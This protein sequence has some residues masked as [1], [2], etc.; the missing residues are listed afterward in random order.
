MN[1]L[2]FRYG[3]TLILLVLSF[4][5]TGIL[6]ASDREVDTFDDLSAWKVVRSAAIAPD[7]DNG[8]KTMKVTGPGLVSRT[9]LFPML[10][11]YGFNRYQGVSFRIRGDGPENH[12]AVGVTGYGDGLYTCYIP[13]KG[14]EW[15]TVVLAWSDFLPPRNSVCKGLGTPDEPWIGID[16]ISFGDYMRFGY[17]RR[18]IPKFNYWIDDF[19]L[20]EAAVPRSSPIKPQQM[21][22]L[23][24]ATAKMKS[25]E[26]ALIY[27][28]GDAISA[29]IGV[30][31][32]CYG[33]LLQEKLRKIYGN[34]K[35][36]V[37]ITAMG[38][39]FDSDALRIFAERDFSGDK[40]DL[41][42]IHIGYDEKR[43]AM[44]PAAFKYILNDY[45]D[46][47]SSLTAGK[48]AV[49]LLPTLPGQGP[50][51]TMMDDYAGIIR[52]IARERGLAVCDIA[53]T[54]KKMGPAR[55]QSHYSDMPYVNAAGHELIAG[56]LADYIANTK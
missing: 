2:S 35:I 14:A 29:G 28:A 45:L 22:P 49:L 18:E 8:N 41:L 21:I 30:G 38:G 17:C 39:G 55:L 31:E 13:V 24:N 52:E 47:V 53:A 23:D 5:V 19:K 3:G 33:N 6:S 56:Q 43:V 10:E 12:V 9:Y 42:L 20:I 44:A 48:T 4:A 54:F 50:L 34:D 27:C 15:Q 32:K 7:L 36:K 37:K 16:T 51:F 46:R 40:P 11:R 25:G 26:P 1:T